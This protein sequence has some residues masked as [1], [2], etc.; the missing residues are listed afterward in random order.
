MEC[1]KE[2]GER[3]D[4]TGLGQWTGQEKRASEVATNDKNCGGEKLPELG[5]TY[6]PL[7][8]AVFTVFAIRN[9]WV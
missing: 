2:W 8:Y 5:R 1:E 6:C 7:A 4:V 3:V 9:S